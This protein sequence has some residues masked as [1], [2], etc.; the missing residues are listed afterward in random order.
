MIEINIKNQSTTNFAAPF[1]CVKTI[2]TAL[3]SLI[4]WL[5]L[6]VWAFWN[7]YLKKCIYYL[8]GHPRLQG[9]ISHFGVLLAALEVSG[10][11]VLNWG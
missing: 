11:M 2:L 9:L 10:A 3:L 1:D 6:L 4:S 7:L 5:L 8:G